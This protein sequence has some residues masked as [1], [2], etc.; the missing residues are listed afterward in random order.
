MKKIIQKSAL[1]L[2]LLSLLIS[3]IAQAEGGDFKVESQL[4]VNSGAA[5]LI[6]EN[7]DKA[8]GVI[9]QLSEGE[10]FELLSQSEEWAEILVFNETG[11]TLM[12]WILQEGIR[13]KTA[14][15]G[16]SF[17]TVNNPDTSMRLILREKPQKSSKSQ[18]KYYNGVTA[19]VL[20]QP[21][22]GW[23]KVRIG[24]LEGYFEEAFVALDAPAGSV[25]SKIP[26]VTV[27]NPDASGL[28]LRSAQ[29]F[30]SETKA[31]NSNGR[32]VRV[33]GVTED[34][35]H[36]L[37]EDGLTG[38]MMAWGVTPQPAYADIDNAVTFSQTN[39]AD[40]DSTVLLPQ[41]EGTQTTIDNPGGQGAQL[42]KRA[43]T[44]SDSL[45]LYRNGTVVI[46][47]GGGEYWKK[48]WVEGRSGW[49]MAKFLTGMLPVEFQ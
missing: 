37:T 16:S 9:R 10:A 42:R 28:N 13:L 31:T 25:Q 46:V 39:K 40:K 23:V 26:T 38:F 27:S 44:S 4:Y 36:V 8:S 1:M 7:A 47:T 3:L 33:L 32:S 5:R 49:M 19:L 29:S 34:F 22:K 15:D 43:S 48:V 18:G 21:Q 17:A 45:G 35:V 6:Y 24:D 14:E 41:P 30:K 20:Q 12:G 11:E 2:L